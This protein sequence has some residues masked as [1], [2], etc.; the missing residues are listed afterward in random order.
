MTDTVT[1]SKYKTI[2]G[3]GGNASND[4]S[5]EKLRNTG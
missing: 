4:K 1:Y 5:Q 3:D 2:L